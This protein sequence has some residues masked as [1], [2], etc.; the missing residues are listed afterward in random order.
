ME[1]S[2]CPALSASVHSGPLHSEATAPPAPAPTS[3][4]NRRRHRAARYRVS[5][6]SLIEQDLPRANLRIACARIHGTSHETLCRA[7][8]GQGSESCQVTQNPEQVCSAGR[9]MAKQ[10]QQPMPTADVADEDKPSGDMYD[11]WCA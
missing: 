5:S 10:I 8:T 2:F 1:K 9:I 11:C 3:P 7:G 6:N 4:S